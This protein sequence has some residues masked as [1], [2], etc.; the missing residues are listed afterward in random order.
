MDNT[1]DDKNIIVMKLLHYFITQKNYNPIILQGAENEIW[2]ENMD[3]DYKIVRIVS[4]HIHNEEQFEYDLFKTK[5]VVKKI[6]RKTLTFNI[7]VLTIFTDINEG[8]TLD[9][10]KNYDCIYLNDEKDIKK[11]NFVTEH[12]PD[13]TKKLKFSEE[14]MQLF[15]KITSDINKKNKHDQIEAEDVFSPKKP[16][17]T[18]ILIFINIFIYL[19]ML[20]SGKFDYYVLKFA[21]YGPSI[22]ENHEFYRLLTGAF[23]HANI[24]HLLFNCYALF[25]IGSQVESFMGKVKYL[26]IYLFSALTGSLLSITLNKAGLSVGASEAIFGLMGSLLY[27]GYHHRVYLGSVIRSQIIPLIIVNLLI[28][29]LSNGQIDNFAHIGG[30]I[31]GFLI[32]IAVGVKYK[33]SKFEM[34]NGLVA[35]LMF[36]VF[37][38][39]LAFKVI[40]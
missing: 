22:I 6:K 13:I 16:I 37:M 9:N 31:G 36:V 8:L 24:F 20:L 23:L 39:L 5:H 14:G 21:T 26:I 19:F 18:N 33:S 1:I 32:T 10:Y 3:S 34:I 4:N 38:L 29:F 7:N 25:I 30:L 11:Y 28:G 35:S 40:A 2:L 15:L 12:F 27:F 17:I